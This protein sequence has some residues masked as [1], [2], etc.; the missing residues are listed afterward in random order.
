MKQGLNRS[1]CLKTYT[2]PYILT[3]YVI[4]LNKLIKET[5]LMNF[6]FYNTLPLEARNIRQ[7]VFVTEQGFQQEFDNI[8]SIAT[9]L[10]IFEGEVAVATARLFKGKTEK[11]F[12]VGRIAVLPEYRKQ[13]L[14]AK[15]MELLENK[16]QELGGKT[17]YLLAQCRAQNFYEKQGYQA[18]GETTM[19]EACPHINMAKTL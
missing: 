17:I 15:I 3:Q 13:H 1:L 8:D 16:V 2:V 9:H 12:I 14:G 11:D 10:V 4:M 6:K 19:D 7:Q 5:L 18:Q